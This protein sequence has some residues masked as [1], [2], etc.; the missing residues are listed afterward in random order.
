MALEGSLTDFGLADILQLIYFQ[1]KT[2]VLSLEG[3]MDRVTLLFIDGNIVAAESKKRVEDNRIGKILLKKEMVKDSDLQNALEEQ[4]R[5]GARL[6]NILIKRELVAK[7]AVTEILKSQITETV[8]QLFGWKQGTYEFTSQGVPRDSVTSIS[9]DTQ[10]LLMEGLRIM[11]EWSLIRGKI[12]LNTVYSRTQGMIPELTAEEEEIYRYVDGEI[13]VSTIID[14]SEKDSFEA[15]K[16]LL[17][18][19]DKGVVHEV[20]A[21]PVISGAAADEKKTGTSLLRFLPLPVVVFSLLISFA[22]V[23]LEKNHEYT[24]YKVA[25]EIVGLRLKIEA[26][27]LRH[28]EYPPTL[29]AVT[30]MNDPWGRPYIYEPVGDTFALVSSGPDGKAGTPDDIF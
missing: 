1:R 26:Y 15:S 19:T 17:R 30:H 4:R 11:D 5:T 6:G 27:K 3:R 20:E 13:D 9:I 18:L 29:E 10:H 25:R 23:L 22:P 16:I 24:E 2:G 7:E 12:T 8:I 28:S 14:L 21:R